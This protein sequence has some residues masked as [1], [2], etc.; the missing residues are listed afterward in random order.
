MANHP[1][2]NRQGFVS[3]LDLQIQPFLL[4]TSPGGGEKP[5]LWKREFSG[6]VPEEGKKSGT[7]ISPYHD[8]HD[9]PTLSFSSESKGNSMG[10]KYR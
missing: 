1:S 7:H 2:G 10:V 6:Q 4:R 5:F 9:G 8:G 3:L